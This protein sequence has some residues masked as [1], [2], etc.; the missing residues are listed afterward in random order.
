MLFTLI[1]NRMIKG[2]S[3]LHKMNLQKRLAP[4][5]GNNVLIG[6]G[7]IIVGNRKVGDNAKIG[8][9]AIVA[10]DVPSA[11]VMVSPPMRILQ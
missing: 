6:A 11:A 10:K 3:H 4:T 8:A 9:G 2:I 5:I 1:V 7:A